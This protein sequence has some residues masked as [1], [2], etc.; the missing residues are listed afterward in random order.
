VKSKARKEK[1]KGKRGER[2]RQERQKMRRGG[3][4]R[5]GPHHLENC[6]NKTAGLDKGLVLICTYG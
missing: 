1:R 3:N 2:G 5:A 6:L 4:K